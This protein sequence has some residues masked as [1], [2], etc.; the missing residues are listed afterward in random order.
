MKKIQLDKDKQTDI[1]KSIQRF[2]LTER[3]EKLS[4]FQA[5]IILDFILNDVGI[6]IYNQALS[7][8]HNLML[9]KIEEIFSLEKHST[10]DTRR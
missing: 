1:I 10:T 4:E 3:D 7:D 2:F 5:S 8:C 6:F 9:G